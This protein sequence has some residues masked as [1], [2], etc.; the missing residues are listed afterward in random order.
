MNK[1]MDNKMNSFIY[2]KSLY[3]VPFKEREKDE[4]W[5]ENKAQSEKN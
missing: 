3:N 4:K 1:A 2:L 5:I